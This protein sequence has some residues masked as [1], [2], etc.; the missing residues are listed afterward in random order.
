MYSVVHMLI[1]KLNPT[2]FKFMIGLILGSFTVLHVVYYR[3]DF[4]LVI[5]SAIWLG[6]P[7]FII[8]PS[9]FG[10]MYPTYTLSFFKTQMIKMASFIMN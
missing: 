4:T 7:V 5:F 8:W 10:L 9:G 1:E 2:Y 3:I 6:S